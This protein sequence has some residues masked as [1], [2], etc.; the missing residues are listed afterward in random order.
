MAGGFTQRLGR[1]VAC[2]SSNILILEV[3][4]C[5]TAAGEQ[6]RGDTTGDSE[7][8][9]HDDNGLERDAPS[10]RDQ[11]RQLVALCQEVDNSGY[12]WDC[13]GEEADGEH[14]GGTSLKEGDVGSGHYK[15]GRDHTG[16]NTVY[17][18]VYC[19]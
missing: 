12:D 15:T 17:Q 5:V 1:V 7:Q 10:I 14:G 3:R 6:R 11:L 8:N 13:Q 2:V 18:P 4:N 9:D 16:R 19:Q